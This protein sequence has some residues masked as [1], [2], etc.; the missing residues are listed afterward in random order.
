M[1]STLTLQSIVDSMRA[2]PDLSPVLDAAGFTQEPALTIANDIMQRFLAQGMDWKFNRANTPTFLTVP[3]Q[4]DYVTSVTDLS[5][6]EQGWRIDINNTAVP[7]PIMAME[8]VRDLAQTSYQ[9]NPFN[10]SW[11]PNSL[12]ILGKWQA[13][14]AYPCGYG[15]GFNNPSPIQQF[16]DVNGNILYINSNSLGLGIFSPGFG[17]PTFVPVTTPYGTSGAVQPSLPPNSAAGLTVV[18]GTVTWTVADPNGIA[19][20]IVPIPASSGLTWLISPV[21]QKKPPILTSLQNTLTPLPDEFGYLFRQGFLARA[22]QHAG[23]RNATEA[24]SQWEETIMIAL[25]SADREREEASFYPT[26]GLTSGNPFRYG[27]PVGPAW[28]YDW[29]GGGY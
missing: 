1:A 12:A 25:R 28:P 4:Q 21:Y 2:Y 15:V 8:S 5:W 16:L 27:M 29:Y 6:L 14:T 20:R 13:L 7:K 10:L 22:Y 24:Y 11:V 18:D 23:N 17:A 3:L 9:A 19:I 26:Q